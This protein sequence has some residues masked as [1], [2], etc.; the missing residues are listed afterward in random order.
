MEQANP[1]ILADMDNA[2]GRYGAYQARIETPKIILPSFHWLPH[3][4][5]M[6][7][8]SLATLLLLDTYLPQ[9]T[10]RQT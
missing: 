1:T 6:P 4:A 8:A 2:W 5:Q 3:P 9:P 7:D 10:R